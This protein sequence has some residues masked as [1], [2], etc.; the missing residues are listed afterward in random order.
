[1]LL[2]LLEC[3]DKWGEC[4][5]NATTTP[6]VSKISIIRPFMTKNSER[7]KKHRKSCLQ[8]IHARPEPDSIRTVSLL[9]SQCCQV[10]QTWCEIHAIKVR[11]CLNFPHILYIKLMSQSL[12]IIQLSLLN[13]SHY[14]PKKQLQRHPPSPEDERV[15]LRVV[16]WDN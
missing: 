9:V 1:M 14:A 12:G 10:K 5:C 15:Y 2:S 13:I 11:I 8:V 4:N 6:F 16:G 7:G 3:E